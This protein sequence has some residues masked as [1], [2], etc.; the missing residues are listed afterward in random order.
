MAAGFFVFSAR[1]TAWDATF[2]PSSTGVRLLAGF[3]MR[4]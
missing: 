3:C 4:G 2:K 1:P